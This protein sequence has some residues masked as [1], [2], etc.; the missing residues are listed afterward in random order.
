M[1]IF[2]EPVAFEWDR[3]NTDKNLKKHG[4]KNQ[5]AEEAFF[6]EPCLVFEDEGHSHQ[7]KRHMLWGR[8]NDGRKLTIIFTI[9]KDRVRVIS[10]RDMSKKERRAYAK[11]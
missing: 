6:N 5:E 9:R 4:V 2:P 11:K 1:K 3:A 10:A 7:E 8:S